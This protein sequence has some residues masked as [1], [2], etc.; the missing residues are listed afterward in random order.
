MV[1]LMHPIEIDDQN[2][3]Y[4]N[5]RKLTIPMVKIDDHD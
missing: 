2:R 4:K 1:G 5:Y 3:N